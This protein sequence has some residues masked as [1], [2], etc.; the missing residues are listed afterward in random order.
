MNARFFCLAAALTLAPPAAQAQTTLAQDNAGAAVYANGFAGLNGGTGFDAFNVVTST[1]G[2]GSAGTFVYTAGQSEGDAANAAI[3]TGGLSFGTYASG[4]SVGA[5]DP[6]VTVTR[7]FA[8][9]PTVGDSFSLDFVG[10]YND[11]GTVG[12]SLLGASG[13]FGSFV[14][15]GGGPGVLFNGQSTGIGFVSGPTHLV[16]TVSSATTYSL[17][18]TGADAFTG[19]GTFSGLI[20]G[21]EFQQVN[22]SGGV[23][24]PATTGPDHNAYF[25][26]LLETA[27]AAAPV[28]EASSS[29]GFGLLLAFGG[30]AA[31]RRFLCS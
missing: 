2:G 21:F 16:Y 12:V 29:I 25:N 13:T 30:I 15:Q 19:S 6:S 22:A 18:A 17:T 28:P 7:T 14:F 10:G 31:A 5:S 3:D 8:T 20:T 26:N 23:G 24:T 11:G 1:P 4:L 27:P 9:G